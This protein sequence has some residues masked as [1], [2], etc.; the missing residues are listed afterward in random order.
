MYKILFT[1]F[2]GLLLVAT[3]SLAEIQLN[4]PNSN[5]ATQDIPLVDEAFQV[6]AQVVDQ[7]IL[8]TW[9]ILENTYLYRHALEF[10]AQQWTLGE[11]VIPAGDKYADE[12]FGEVETYRYDLQ[13]SIPIEQVTAV[14]DTLVVRYQGC[15]DAGIC[16]PPQT[17]RL[18][19]TSA[20]SQAV[21]EAV[22]EVVSETSQAS[23][24]ETT[25]SFGLWELLRFFGYG[26]LLALTPCVFPMA[27]ILSRI[28]VGPDGVSRGSRAVS[29]SLTYV[30]STAVVFAIAG[31]AVGALGGNFITQLQHPVAYLMFALLFVVLALS[32]FGLYKIEMPVKLQTWVTGVSN[33]QKPGSFLGAIMMGVL[34]AF[35]V[36]GCATPF[37]LAALV[38]IAQSGDTVSGALALFLLALG[39][40]APL[41]VVA[42]VAGQFLP[43]AGG[44]MQ[45]VQT[46]IGVLML[47]LALLMLHRVG[48]WPELLWAWL[49]L[50]VLAAVVILWR[51]RNAELTLLLTVILIT[52][53]AYMGAKPWLVSSWDHYFGTEHQSEQFTPIKGIS[54]LQTAMS[55]GGQPFYML[56][57]YADWCVSCIEMEHTTFQDEGVQAAWQNFGLLQTD[58]TLNDDV[59]QALLKAYQLP[60]P[61][62][63]LFF[64]RDGDGQ[65]QELSQWRVVGKMP[66]SDFIDR[67]RL[68]QSVY[69]QSTE[70]IE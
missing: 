31:A 47:A 54:G 59:D 55:T 42:T 53:T 9:Q 56:D 49:G 57:F 7:D 68:V 24:Q 45:Q 39:M 36:S 48:G 3:A 10:N 44:W 33:Q 66:A 62:A 4:L 30:L 35:L 15:A 17:V 70:S 2:W 6:S 5:P 37:L 65:L 64:V 69:P 25:T 67:L 52:V 32:M 50:Y 14:D 60:G 43:K 11:P 63:I 34:A 8:V 23:A 40:G 16:Y 28:I 29:L 13:V 61:P 26:L 12:Y 41:V 27:P 20:V 22:S 21:S 1:C 51:H 58:V 38:E 18:G 46:C 19:L